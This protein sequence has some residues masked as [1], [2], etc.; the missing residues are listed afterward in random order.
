MQHDP[1]VR[2]DLR[3]RARAVRE[4]RKVGVP[5]ALLPG[6]AGPSGTDAD[7]N[8]RDRGGAMEPHS[9][10]GGA[11]FRCPP[12]VLRDRHGGAGP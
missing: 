9:G 10:A 12:V 7:G 3:D 8:E 6:V 1:V 11:G 2:G 4:P 5:V